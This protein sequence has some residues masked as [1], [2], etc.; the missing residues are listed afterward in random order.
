M[1][2]EKVYGVL[3]VRVPR[4]YEKSLHC[5]DRGTPKPKAHA[6]VIQDGNSTT[7]SQFT[8]NIHMGVALG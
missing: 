6:S 4:E 7:G 2:I 8:A 1:Q 5:S 3:L